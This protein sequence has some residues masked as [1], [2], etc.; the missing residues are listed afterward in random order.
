[1]MADLAIVSLHEKGFWQADLYH[2]ASHLRGDEMEQMGLVP[3]A[4][5][6]SK[7]DAGVEEAL[8]WVKENW[9]Q[10]E[11]KVVEEVEDDEE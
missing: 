11:V 8:S 9:P 3:D 5:H 6:T 4:F 10:S 2:D 7:R 1:M